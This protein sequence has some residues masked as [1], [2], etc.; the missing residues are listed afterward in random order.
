MSMNVK[1]FGF[2]CLVGLCSSIAQLARYIALSIAPA[3]VVAPLIS[4]SP[5]F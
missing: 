4:I 3:S 5:V 1:A 2:F